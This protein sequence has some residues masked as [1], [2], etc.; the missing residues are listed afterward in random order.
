[1]TLNNLGR[2]HSLGPASDQGASPRDLGLAFKWA[3]AFNIGYVR[4]GRTSP[5][6][7]D[8]LPGSG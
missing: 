5:S 6:R 2:D 3:V 7:D 8:R 1:M 4:H